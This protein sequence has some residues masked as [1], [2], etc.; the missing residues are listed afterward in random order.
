M[1][2]TIEYDAFMTLQHGIGFFTASPCD[3][4]G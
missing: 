2:R 4:A 3:L 1:E